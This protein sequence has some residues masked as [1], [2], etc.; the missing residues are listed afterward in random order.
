MRRYRSW[1]AN[2]VGAFNDMPVP[3]LVMETLGNMGLTIATNNGLGSPT[4]NDKGSL[5]NTS[6]QV[7]GRRSMEVLKAMIHL[8]HN[9]PRWCS[10]N[11]LNQIKFT[12]E[13]VSA[14]VYSMTWHHNKAPTR[15]NYT[16][17]VLYLF[18]RMVS[19]IWSG[20]EMVRKVPDW[21][22]IEDVVLSVGGYNTFVGVFSH[23]VLLNAFCL[24]MPEIH[25]ALCKRFFSD[26]FRL[27]KAFGV[28]C[29]KQCLMV[30]Y[31]H[32]PTV[33]S[34]EK[35]HENQKALSMAMDEINSKRTRPD[36]EYLGEYAP[37]FPEK[38]MSKL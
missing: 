19:R 23:P 7:D 18:L 12:D 36:G 15:C 27:R 8:Y 5:V 31:K 24:A 34:V 4:F 30:L 11:L 21:K 35:L 32:L 20:G 33:D 25:E 1:G 10:E 37:P 9:V 6:V 29:W 26:D 22:N 28:K 17:K 16:V 14:R 3:N 38:K 2:I 13:S